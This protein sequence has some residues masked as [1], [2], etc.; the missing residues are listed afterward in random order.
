MSP[1]V[2][3][4]SLKWLVTQASS[5]EIAF[6]DAD[7][8]VRRRF[9]ITSPLFA[10]DGS[11]L[12]TLGGEPDVRWSGRNSLLKSADQVGEVVATVHYRTRLPAN[13]VFG[14]STE[15]DYWMNLHG[16][17]GRKLVSDIKLP[18]MPVGRDATHIYVTDYGPDGRHSAP[19][20]LKI[21]RVPVKAG[22][23]GFRH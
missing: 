15:F 10:D 4:E 6:Y 17:D 21:L 8:V 12:K 5:K 2:G 14:Q 22:T 20:K 11:V 23:N 1:I 18:G 13:Y 7:G 9:D 19:D 16:L 3:D